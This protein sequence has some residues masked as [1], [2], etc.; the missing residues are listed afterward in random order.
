M[1]FV[2]FYLAII[3]GGMGG[4]TSLSAHPRV[5]PVVG[6][7]VCPSMAAPIADATPCFIPSNSVER[8]RRVVHRKPTQEVLDKSVLKAPDNLAQNP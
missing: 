2:Y 1:S 3:S 8:H 7:E 4:L 6:E 5:A